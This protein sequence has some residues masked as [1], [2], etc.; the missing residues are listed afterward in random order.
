MSGCIKNDFTDSF[1]S[2]DA[3]LTLSVS[4]STLTANLELF[5]KPTIK[6]D[7][8]V[9]PGQNFVTGSGTFQSSDFT[10]GT[11]IIDKLVQLEQSSVFISATLQS[12]CETKI[13]LTGFRVSN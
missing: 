5:P 6:F 1:G 9:S 4:G 13:D 12:T 10:S 11:I 2:T 8:G 3:D 7:A